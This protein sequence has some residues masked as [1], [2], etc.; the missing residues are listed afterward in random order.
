M[1]GQWDGANSDISSSKCIIKMTNIFRI[2]QDLLK[3]LKLGIKKVK[4]PI[5]GGEKKKKEKSLIE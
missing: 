1:T 4:N 5:L 3:F 2:N